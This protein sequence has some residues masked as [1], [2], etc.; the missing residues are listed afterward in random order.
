MEHLPPILFLLAVFLLLLALMLKGW[1]SRAS[2]QVGAGLPAPRPLPSAADVPSAAAAGVY[3]ATTSAQ[4]HLERIAAHGLGSR[5]RVSLVPGPETAHGAW[6]I[7]REGA[8]S[9]AIP[10]EDLV[11]ITTAPGM[12]GKW[13]GGDALLVLRWRLG[14]ELLDT[15]VR[16][17]SRADHDR[18]L[19]HA[20]HSDP[21]S[22][23]I[24]WK[25]TP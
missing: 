8:P 16:L 11:E 9:F 25:E 15:G 22:D 19:A 6:E 21:T 18:L 1:R 10:A 3:V 20:P 2:R 24:S 14:A 23:P 5:S 7:R 4:R 17:D 12:V 13:M